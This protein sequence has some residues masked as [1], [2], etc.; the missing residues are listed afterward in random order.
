MSWF[1]K[2]GKY[3]YFVER[4]N[5]YEI[6]HYVGDDHKIKEKLI[7]YDPLKCPKCKSVLS[8]TTEGYYCSFCNK[9]FILLPK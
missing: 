4:E 8:K 7:N 2:K 1:R 9:L 3:W 5:E 6:Q